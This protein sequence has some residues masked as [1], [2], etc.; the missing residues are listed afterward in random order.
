MHLQIFLLLE[1]IIYH[2]QEKSRPLGA[3]LTLC[4]HLLWR[5]RMKLLEFCNT[6]LLGVAVP[7]CLLFAGAFFLVRLRAFP[8]LRPIRLIR[9]VLKR[10]KRGGFFMR[11]PPFIRGKST[12][13]RF[14]H[15][16]IPPGSR[17]YFSKKEGRCSCIGLLFQF[18]GM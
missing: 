3:N 8:F 5:M 11:Q 13:S 10:D 17:Q 9:T 6:Y 1:Y 14:P 15:D 12:V 18:V 16:S 2:F 4:I 7:L